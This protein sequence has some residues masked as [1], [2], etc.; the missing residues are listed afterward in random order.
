MEDNFKKQVKEQIVKIENDIYE[1]VHE[2]KRL[3][4]VIGRLRAER[5]KMK[6]LLGIKVKSGRPKK[7]HNSSEEQPKGHVITM[8]S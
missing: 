5:T 3:K 7:E 2:W 6:I 1:K 8:M 4:T